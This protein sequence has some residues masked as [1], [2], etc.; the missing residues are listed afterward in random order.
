[1]QETYQKRNADF[2]F[3]ISEKQWEE[4]FQHWKSTAWKETSACL[5]RFQEQEQTLWTASGAGER[6][7]SVGKGLWE[8]EFLFQRLSSNI[9]LWFFRN[10]EARLDSLTLK[11]T[12]IQLPQIPN[13]FPKVCLDITQISIIIY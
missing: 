13:S 6:Q 11:S 5:C 9:R 3:S 10:A 1:M 7:I 8:A 2:V 4:S 12:K